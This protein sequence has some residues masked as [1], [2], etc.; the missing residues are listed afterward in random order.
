MKNTIIIILGLL[1]ILLLLDETGV[2]DIIITGPNYCD[3]K[4]RY[5]AN[6]S[7]GGGMMLSSGDAAKAMIDSYRAS[8]PD[9][10]RDNTPKGGFISKRVF[11][12]I[13]DSRN[14]NGVYYYFVY[15]ANGKMNL[16]LEGGRSNYTKIEETAG[17]TG[18][19]VFITKTLCPLDCGSCGQ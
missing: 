4:G 11:D 3:D 5:E 17:V 10:V 15:D 2:V 14:N 8:L 9:D 1:V 12:R 7:T 18:S 19:G 16:V 13:F 6:E